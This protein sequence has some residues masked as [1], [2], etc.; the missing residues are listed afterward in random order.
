[1]VRVRLEGIT[2]KSGIIT[3]SVQ[4]Y[5]GYLPGPGEVK[6]Q[7]MYLFY[8]RRTRYTCIC[9]L[10]IKLT[11]KLK[12]RHV[13]F[14]NV[15]FFVYVVFYKSRQFSFESPIIVWV[16]LVH[17]YSCQLLNFIEINMS[18]WQDIYV[19]CKIIG[20]VTVIQFSNSLINTSLK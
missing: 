7:C 20:D 6:M 15:D 18:F 12:P 9:L 5:E 3:F 11:K 1:M 13:A 10:P 2:S 16:S 19:W 14:Y 8:W 4:V 17:I